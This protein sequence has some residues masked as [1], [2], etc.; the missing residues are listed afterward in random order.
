[1]KTARD[2]DEDNVNSHEVEVSISD[3]RMPQRWKKSKTYRC[4]VMRFGLLLRSRLWCL[5]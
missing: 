5:L 1:M 4:S 3:V 2:T